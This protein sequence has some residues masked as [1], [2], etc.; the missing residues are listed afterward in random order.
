MEWKGKC[1]DNRE[2]KAKAKAKRNSKSGINIEN[3]ITFPWVT[4]RHIGLSAYN[5]RERW[6]DNGYQ[7]REQ[8]WLR[9][10]ASSG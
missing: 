10:L 2:E 9:S 6:I 7:V 1:L 5:E 8:E 4:G 3:C